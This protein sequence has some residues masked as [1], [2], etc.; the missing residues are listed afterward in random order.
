MKKIKTMSIALLSGAFI[1]SSMGT[2][3]AMVGAD[4]KPV[5]VPSSPDEVVIMTA[6]ADGGDSTVNP[7]GSVEHEAVILPVPLDPNGKEIYPIKAPTE[8]EKVE[9]DH[10]IYYLNGEKT[11]VIELNGKKIDLKDAT[12]YGKNG[13]L[14][15]PLRVVA[16][17]IGYKV[18]WNGN[19]QSV[20]L[21]NGS[22]FTKVY[23]GKD[24][25]FYGKMTPIQFGVAPEVKNNQTYVPLN[26][27]FDILKAKATIDGK[28]KVFKINTE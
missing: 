2:A 24:S 28:E 8:K 17:A 11:N 7:N 18:T 26:F 13:K 5:V 6:P 19:E 20:E 15:V 23:I 27:V 12:L 16:E 21:S 1:F 22:N 9:S 10:T 14:M 25:Y 4:G 3:S